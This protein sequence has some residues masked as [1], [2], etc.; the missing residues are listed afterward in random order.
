MQSL[1]NKNSIILL[2]IGVS[3]LIVFGYFISRDNELGLFSVYGVLIGMFLYAYPFWDI[4]N[5]INLKFKQIIFLAIV[6]RLVLLFMTPNLSDDYY[7]F[8]WDG[9]II[10]SGNN[11]Y[12]F[13]PNNQEFNSIKDKITL[14]DRTFVGNEAFPD[15]M[16]SKNY[17]SVY[18]PVN[19]VIFGV[20]SFFAGN[21]NWSNILFLRIIIIAFDLGVIIQLTS[22]LKWFSKKKELIII[23]AL[24]PLV[25]TELTGNLHFE[26]VTIF[27]VLAAILLILKHKYLQSG[28]IYSLA[29]GTKLIPLI[30]L[31]VFLFKLNWKRLIIF[32]TRWFYVEHLKTGLACAS[33]IHAAFLNSGKWLNSVSRRV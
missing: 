24:N 18:P 16:N 26:G 23:Y 2:L 6:F 25:I 11:P 1:L 8:I 28:L 21:D 15:G 3:S 7:R 10:S 22:L 33:Q 13:T 17:Y 5:K 14:K 12:E 20:S 29:I 19:Q 9:N 31:P 32:Y 27:F 30:L 4:K